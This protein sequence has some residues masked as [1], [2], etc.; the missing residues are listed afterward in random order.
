MENIDTSEIDLLSKNDLIT[1]FNDFL[2]DLLKQLNSIIKNDGD[3]SYCYSVFKDVTKMNHTLVIDQFNINV[4]E[5]YPQI[6]E[7]DINFFLTENEEI[8]KVEGK[9]EGTS[10]IKKIFKFKSLFQ[11]LSTSEKEM[12]FYYLNIL[13]Y[14]GARYFTL[15]NG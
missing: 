9:Y 5:F 11:R 15:V 10:V 2:Y 7:K 6:K 1:L 4:L 14:I 12:F 13:C 8:K 3:L